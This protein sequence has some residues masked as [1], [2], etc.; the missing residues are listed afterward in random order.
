M[1]LN[2]AS[3]ASI[4]FVILYFPLFSILSVLIYGYTPDGM[5]IYSNYP[6]LAFHVVLRIAAEA[7]RIAFGATG[8]S[9]YSLLAAHYTLGVQGYFFL[10]VACYSFSVSWQPPHSEFLEGDCS[11]TGRSW[12]KFGNPFGNSFKLGRRFRPISLIIYVPVVANSTVITGGCKLSNGLSDDPDALLTAKIMSIAGQSVFLAAVC[13]FLY[14][15]IEAIHETRRQS[16]TRKTPTMVKILLS[17]WI[18]LLIRGI[19]CILSTTVPALSFFNLENYLE[20]DNTSFVVAEYV[21]GETIE[22][23]ACVLMIV[24]C[25]FDNEPDGDQAQIQYPDTE[26]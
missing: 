11:G 14:C 3:I 13:Y 6:L 9:N 7:L 21:L 16:R 26:M 20:G 19:Y 8:D 17:V 12:P 18:L 1:T 25:L 15:W 22:W 24:T 5:R 4:V 10:L 2:P 23:V